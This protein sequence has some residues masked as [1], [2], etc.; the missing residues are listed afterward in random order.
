[1]H[2]LTVAEALVE[3]D[4]FDDL[5]AESRADR[6]VDLFPVQR[7]VAVGLGGELLVSCQPRLALG[8]PGFRV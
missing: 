3:V 7:P 5:A 4:A 6:D 2:Q 8:L 1:V